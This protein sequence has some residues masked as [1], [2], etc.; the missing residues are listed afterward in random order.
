MGA[1]GDP[2][3]ERLEHRP[4]RSFWQSAVMITGAALELH[5]LGAKQRTRILRHQSDEPDG[6]RSWQGRG[7]PPEDVHRT[8]L[9]AAQS[10]E[11][12]EEGGLAG[13]VSA[14]DR[15]DFAGVKVERHAGE[16]RN[17]A[18]TRGQPLDPRHAIA[19][20]CGD[21]GPRRRLE[22]LPKRRR[23]ATGISHRQWDGRPAGL[24]GEA[25][26]RRCELRGC[27]DLRRRPDSHAG[28]AGTDRHDDVGEMHDALEPVLSDEDR[29]ALVVHEARQRR[30]HLLGR[31]R[32][33]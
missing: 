33:Q 26:D 9:G 21:V 29:R 12:V 23:V 14:H 16:G 22:A 13:S 28:R 20:R 2:G 10:D 32:V 17:R 15:D 11:V 8:S 4:S 25:D 5:G 18:V 30:Q 3:N 31:D 27:E 7:L 24:T 1:R 19:G 6:L